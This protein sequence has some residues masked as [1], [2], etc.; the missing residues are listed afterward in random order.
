MSDVTQLSDEELL[1]IIQA[2]GDVQPVDASTGEALNP[3]QAQTYR[4]LNAAGGI[5]PNAQG[6]SPRLPLAQRAPEDTPSP[7]QFFVDT[8]GKVQKQRDPEAEYLRSAITRAMPLVGPAVEMLQNG[9]ERAF[10]T[11]VPVLGAFADEANAGLN[12]ALSP[13]VEPLLRGLESL[14]VSTPYDEQ[15]RLSKDGNKFADRYAQALSLE[16]LQNDAARSANPDAVGAGMVAGTVAAIPY[17][18]SAALGAETGL[19]A[20]MGVGALEGAGVGGLQG[21]GEGAGSYDDPSRAR[22]AGMG[23]VIG[24]GVGAGFPVAMKAGGA[25]WKATGGKVMDAVRSRMSPAIAAEPDVQALA[26]MTGGEVGMPRALAQGGDRDLADLLATITASPKVP[27]VAPSQMDDAYARIARAAQRQGQTSDQLAEAVAKLGPRGVL[28]DSGQSM[29]DLTRAAMNRPSGAEDIA[30]KNL[31]LRQEGLRD[32][33]EYVARPSSSRI[34]DE[35]A[36]GMGVGEKSYL[37]TFDNLNKIQKEAADPLYAQVREIGATDSPTLQS[38]MARPSMKK[39]IARAYRIAKEEGRN[40]EDLAIVSVESPGNWV[41]SLPPEDQVVLQA[42]GVILKRGGAGKAPT[43]GPSLAKFLADNG[44]VVDDGGDLAAMG[45]GD[46]NKGKAYQRG[47]IAKAAE[48]QGA[49]PGTAPKAYQPGGTSA[50]DAALKAWEAGYFPQWK[51]RP[52]T[53]ELYDALADELRGKPRYARDM[54]ADLTD[55]L[56]LRDEADEAVYRGGAEPPP[57]PDDYTG[58]PMPTDEPAYEAQPTAETWDFVKRGL[59]DELETY[60]NKTTG[61][62]VLNDEGRAV[63]KTLKELRGELVNLNPVY[64]EALN[65]YSGPAAMKDALEAGKGAFRENGEGLQRKFST[66][67]S[68]ER[69]MY[70]LGAVQ[71][72]RD[73]L[74]NADVTY[75][76]AQRAGLLKPNQLE[77]F[78]ELFPSETAFRSFVETMDREAAMFSTRSDLFRQSTTA[79]QLANSGEESPIAGL[80]ETAVNIKT[81]GI[82]AILRALNNIGAPKMSE[83][84]AEAIAAITTNLDQSQLPAIISRIEKMS[85]TEALAAALKRSTGYGAT[86]T[87]AGAPTERA[88]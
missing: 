77:R 12:A 66:M 88:R 7:G 60:R 10:S 72:L 41:S 75:N 56:R 4:Q 32:G 17:L 87:A 35:A 23:A 29:R 70:R 33:G 2:G 25:A 38:L 74:G 15:F 78:K 64:G 73:K 76:A 22:G 21:Y 36:S 40:P 53:R 6:G 26:Q 24:G 48:A 54:S 81:G 57:S 84:T 85:S 28:A 83:P 39:A 16:R 86:T 27:Q 79:K 9:G 1:A 67:N 43:Q 5:D 20:R 8:Q 3:A 55:R 59:D 49:L 19:L 51:E 52:T 30:R 80:M 71:A 44:G 13:T 61:E 82:P 37:D 46:W 63:Q 65:A 31:N 45:A 50:D 58:R 11:G 14:G 69:E 68:G 34:V 47:L 18:P 42:Q 62:L